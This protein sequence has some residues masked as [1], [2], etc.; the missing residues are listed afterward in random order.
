[1]G[2]GIDWFGDGYQLG[3]LTG[4]VLDNTGWGDSLVKAYDEGNP[5]VETVYKWG[6]DIGDGLETTA[7]T[8]CEQN[9]SDH[10]VS[11]VLISA[12]SAVVEAGDMLSFGSITRAEKATAQHILE[13]NPGAADVMIA[14][15]DTLKENGILSIPG[16]AATVTGTTIMVGDG[17]SQSAEQ[18]FGDPNKRVGFLGYWAARFSKT[19]VGAFMVAAARKTKDWI[20]ELPCGGKFHTSYA[21]KNMSFSDIMNEVKSDAQATI[22]LYNQQQ[23]EA[24]ATPTDGQTVDPNAQ[25][26]PPVPTTGPSPTP[27]SSH[28]SGGGSSSQDRQGMADAIDPTQQDTGNIPSADY[29]K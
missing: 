2:L 26:T 16:V 1:M 29:Q 25:T 12:G 21:E 5:V 13:N 7:A 28:S 17:I 8:I 4:W 27:T 18:I 20:E 6:T 24:A 14:A 3:D 19:S 10:P 11:S 15:S 9:W 22:D 23:T